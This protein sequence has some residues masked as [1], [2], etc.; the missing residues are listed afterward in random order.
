MALEDRTVLDDLMD[1]V[2]NVKKAMDDHNLLRDCL[3]QS[4]NVTLM[5]NLQREQLMNGLRSDGNLI[6]PSIIKDP[7]F[8]SLKSARKYAMRKM[9]NFPN[10]NRPFQTP[11]LFISGYFHS[12]FVPVFMADSVYMDNTNKQIPGRFGTADLYLKYGMDTFGLTDSSWDSVLQIT[13][14]KLLNRIY[15]EL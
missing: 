3:S 6:T 1:R 8:K 2:E 14:E 11:N 9:K 12:G 5:C 10:Y 13:R 7:F 15:D 4:D